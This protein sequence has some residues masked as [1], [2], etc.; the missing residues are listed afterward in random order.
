MS[1]NEYWFAK[2]FIEETA[3]LLLLKVQTNVFKVPESSNFIWDQVSF[4]CAQIKTLDRG[5]FVG[6]ESV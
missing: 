4:D 3:Q 6:D 2:G 5:R 1:P